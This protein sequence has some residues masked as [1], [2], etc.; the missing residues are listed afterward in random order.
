MKMNEEEAKLQT[1]LNDIEN[2]LKEESKTGT[3]KERFLWNQIKASSSLDTYPF[4]E[5]VVDLEH[6]QQLKQEMVDEDFPSKVITITNAAN[7]TPSNGSQYF[8]KYNIKIGIIADEFL[9]KAYENTAELI[10]LTPDNYKDYKDKLDFVWIV[11]TWNGLNEEW[12]GGLGNPQK[13]HYA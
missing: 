4:Q 5:Q 13:H 3:T 6:Y 9:Y 12:K 1:Q 11:T 2:Q 7:V 10:Y 8:H